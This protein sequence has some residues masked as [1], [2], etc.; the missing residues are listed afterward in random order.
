MIPLLGKLQPLVDPGLVGKAKRS[1]HFA[2]CRV[3]QIDAVDGSVSSAFRLRLRRHARVQVRGWDEMDG[4]GR[5]R[6]ID[7]AMHLFR[8]SSPASL[9]K[10]HTRYV[11]SMQLSCRSEAVGA[12][13]RFERRKKERAVQ[14]RGSRLLTAFL[15]LRQFPSLFI[16]GDVPTPTPE[17]CVWTAAGR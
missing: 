15:I 9:H 7:G 1:V 4:C 5:Y 2:R 8:V 6:R 17:V 12:D 14:S 11:A 16:S 13:G 10:T 3:Q